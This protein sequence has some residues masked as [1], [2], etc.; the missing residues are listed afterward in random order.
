[1]KTQKVQLKKIRWDQLEVLQRAL[2]NF[3][4]AMHRFLDG[5]TYY[6]AIITMDLTM[7]IHCKLQKTSETQKN[8]Y[9]ISLTLAEAATILKMIKNTPTQDAYWLATFEKIKD[10]LIQQFFKITF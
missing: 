4:D 5:T 6:D 7:S 1:M 8:K 2:Q 10:Q 9:T 3:H